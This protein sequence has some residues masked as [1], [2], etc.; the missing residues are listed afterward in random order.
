MP[1]VI[2]ESSQAKKRKRADGHTSKRRV[3]QRRDESGSEDDIQEQIL[4]L[5]SDILETG[6][7]QDGVTKLLKTF[8]SKQQ[9]LEARLGSGVA[10]C[11]IFYRFIAAERLVKVKGL[12][13]EEKDEVDWLREHLEVFVRGLCKLLSQ[14]DPQAQSTA[15]TLLMRIVKAEVS[16]SETRSSQAWKNGAFH[17]LVRTLVFQTDLEGPRAE[18]VETF[19]EEHDDVRF[20]TYLAVTRALFELSLAESQRHSATSNALDLL[21][22]VEGIPDSKDQLQDWY[23]TTPEPSTHYLLSLKAHLKQAQEAWLS[24]FKSSLDNDQRKKILDAFTE[25]IA[26]WFSRPEMLMDFL[27]DS[28]DAGGPTSLLALSGVYYLIK[29]RNLDYPQFYAKLYS[30]LDE[31][32]LHS[33]HRARFFRLLEVFLASSHLPAGLVASFIKRLSRLA[34]HAPPGGIVMVVPWVYNMMKKHPQCTF[35]LHRQTKD[36]AQK[37][38]LESSGM[39]D[40]F[41]MLEVDPMETGA[42]ESSLWELASLQHHYHPN[43]ATLAKIIGE[44]FTKQEYNLEDFLDHTY[45][46]LVDAELGKTLKK[47]PVVEFEIPK[48]IVTSD[49]GGLNGIGGLLQKAMGA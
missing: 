45:D 37:A 38:E 46:G 44:Q 21:L 11:R 18:F 43:V 14:D 35:L 34:L 40:P 29:E 36:V 28:Y 27:I 39:D 15:L 10:L 19:V 7:V 16:Q 6:E 3:A 41:D 23:G 2:V 48:R 30:L 12:S 13:L 17:S 22:R 1:G 42:L 47:A 8:K 26:P 32:I 9:D 31:N 4:Q 25:K 33:K 24:I 5:E 49:E 20:Y